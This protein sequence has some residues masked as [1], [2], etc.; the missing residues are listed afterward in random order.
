M[1][2]G[3]SSLSCFNKFHSGSIPPREIF[4]SSPGWQDLPSR[5]LLNL[6]NIKFGALVPKA[7]YVTLVLL[8]KDI[9]KDIVNYTDEYK[10]YQYINVATKAI[11]E[12]GKLN[13][14]KKLIEK[15]KSIK[16]LCNKK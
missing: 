4:A 7:N 14:G 15:Y 10:Y 8:G 11:L 2:N 1:N 3:A 9:N 5:F 13:N 12:E 16:E 6:P